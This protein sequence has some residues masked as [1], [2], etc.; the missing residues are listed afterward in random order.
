MRKKIPY[1]WKLPG[2]VRDCA[3]G[4][5]FFHRIFLT[6]TFRFQNEAGYRRAIDLGSGLLWTVAQAPKQRSKWAGF[7][8]F[9][10]PEVV[11]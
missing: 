3:A 4:S 6:N 11:I 7:N 1:L 2:T 5:G 9:Q 10:L 8:Q